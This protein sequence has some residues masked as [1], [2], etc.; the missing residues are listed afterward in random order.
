MSPLVDFPWP[1]KKRAGVH[2]DLATPSPS[3]QP[4]LGCGAQHSPEGFSYTGS[5]CPEQGWPEL[6]LCSAIQSYGIEI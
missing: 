6:N 3:K 4:L 1:G 2:V 5:L